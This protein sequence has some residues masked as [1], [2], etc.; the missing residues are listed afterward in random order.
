MSLHHVRL[1]HGSPPNPSDG[2]RIGF[3]VRYI[4][5]Y[6]SQVEGKDSASLV[7]GSDTF[8]HFEHEPRPLRDMDPAFVA[9]H[10]RITDQQAQILYRGTP[11]KNFNEPAALPNRGAEQS[12]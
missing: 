2:R 9:L 11:V 7:R 1:V 6:V 3:A 10:Q 5:T 4:P 12:P 8:H